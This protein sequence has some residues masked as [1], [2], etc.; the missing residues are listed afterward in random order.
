MND[1]LAIYLHDHWVGSSFAV[2]LWEKLAKEF[3]GT[4]S[5]NVASELLKEVRADREILKELI[6]RAGEA[7]RGL[8]DMLGWVAERLSRLKLKHEEP[9]DIGAFEAFETLSLGILGK[10]S[11]WEALKARRK[12]DNRLAGVDYEALIARAEQQYQT[13]NSHRLTM[14]DTALSTSR[15]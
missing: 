7:N 14:I 4:T 1:S 5:G 2:E 3:L 6:D 11:L 8:Y 9:G 13:A 12:S 10:R 15:D